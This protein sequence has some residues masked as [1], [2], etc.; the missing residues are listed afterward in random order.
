MINFYFANVSYK[1]SVALLISAARE[2]VGFIKNFNSDNRIGFIKVVSNSISSPD[3]FCSPSNRSGIFAVISAMNLAKG[4]EVVVT[5][6]TCSAVVEPLIQLGVKPVFVDIDPATFCLDPS[7]LESVL[8]DRTR[9]IILQHTFGIP[10]PIQAV[11]EIARRRNVFVIEDC[12]LALGSKKDGRWL[13]TFGDAA[14]WSFELSKTISVGWGGL[15]GINSDPLLAKRVG[16]VIEDAGL[17]NRLLA[18]QRL[19]QVGGSGILYHHNTP[20]VMRRYG[21]AALFK[22]R[23][24]RKSSDT[25]ASDLRL[26]SDRQWKFLLRQWKRLDA[27]LLKSKAAQNVYE[28]VLTSHGCILPLSKFENTETFLIRFPLLV[29][30][31]ERFALFFADKDIEVGRWFSSPV[32]SGERSPTLYGYAWGS[33]PVAEKVCS[34][35]VNLPLHGRLTVGHVELVAA[36]LHD[37][38]SIHPDEVVFI[39]RSWTPGFLKN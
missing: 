3:L 39:Q 24:F 11:M 31:P 2:A 12:A 26:P 22:F 15:I 6:F 7:K 32:S 18:A 29:K 28:E 9:V 23:V 30:D 5:G 35:I 37:Y 21:L 19:L 38:L 4:D 36:T 1:E 27:I 8:N 13:G 20:R 34:H 16:D 10:G 25:P 17:Q 14:V 33:C